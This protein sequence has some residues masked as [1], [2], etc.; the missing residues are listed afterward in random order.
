MK[1]AP[2]NIKTAKVVT[3]PKQQTPFKGKAPIIS[4]PEELNEKINEYFADTS[5]KM[6]VAGLC[7]FLGFESRQSF[8][9]YEKREGYSYTI[10]RAR[11]KIERYYEEKLLT[12]SIQ[13]G[14][15]YMLNTLG[16]DKTRN[17]EPEYPKKPDLSQ[18]SNDDLIKL[19]KGL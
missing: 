16:Y 10:K 12:P 2:K 18:L 1:I 8:Y 19:A 14:C 11:L 9:D 3:T 15:I 4:S 13:T 7:E 17:L 6:T 5:R